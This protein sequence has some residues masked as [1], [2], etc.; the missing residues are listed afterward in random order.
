MAH[1]EGIVNGGFQSVT[2]MHILAAKR[3]RVALVVV[4]L[5]LPRAVMCPLLGLQNTSRHTEGTSKG[6]VKYSL[7]SP[8][9]STMGLISWVGTSGFTVDYARAARCMICCFDR[10]R[11]IVESSDVFKRECE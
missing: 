11:P 10:E 9:C 8:W 4:S 7:L 5:P 1:A 2:K 6:G 3:P